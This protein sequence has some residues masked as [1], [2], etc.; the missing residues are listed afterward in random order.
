M[1]T[2][3][4]FGQIRNGLWKYFGVHNIQP[5]QSAKFVGNIAIYIMT[6]NISFNLLDLSISAEQ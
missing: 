2:E 6:F 3:L 1:D 5:A 4:I